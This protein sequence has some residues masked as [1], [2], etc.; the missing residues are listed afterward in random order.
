MNLRKDA[1]SH[2][3]IFG[4]VQAPSAIEVILVFIFSAQ[5]ICTRLQSHNTPSSVLNG[6][7]YISQTETVK[8][9]PQKMLINRGS[10]SPVSICK[11]P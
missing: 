6:A 7:G 8:N 3:Y 4:T 2:C 10:T 1:V 11:I 9:I 5:L